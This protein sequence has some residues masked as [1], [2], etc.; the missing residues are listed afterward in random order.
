MQSTLK[1]NGKKEKNQEIK[2][3]KKEEEEK[4]IKNNPTLGLPVWGLENFNES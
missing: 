2:K 4:K 1:E 3:N